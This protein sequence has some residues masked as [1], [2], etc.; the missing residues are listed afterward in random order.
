MKKKS[1]FSA[2]PNRPLGVLVKLKKFLNYLLDFVFPKF[3]LGCQQEGSFC[4]QKCLDELQILPPEPNPWPEQ[5]N[6][7]EACYVCLNYQNKLIEKIIKNYKYK[8]LENLSDYLVEILAKQFN[9]LNLKDEL[10]ITNVPL[11]KAKKKQRGFDQ[12]EILAKKL[13]IKL[14]YQ[15]QPLLIRHKKTK[16]QAKLS[17]IAREENLKNAFSPINPSLKINSPVLLIDDIAT[18]GATLN[19]ATKIIKELGAEK[20]ICLVLAKN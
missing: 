15:Y 8:Y 17:K 7:F 10:I 19:S 3:C 2:L 13:A 6:S 11:N 14:N 4:C 1:E 12:T 5:K 20:V 16:T 9:N 18:T